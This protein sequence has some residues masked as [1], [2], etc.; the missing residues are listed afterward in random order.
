MQCCIS[1][2]T[3]KNILPL[4]NCS[5]N[6]VLKKIIEINE[7]NEPFSEDARIVF[8]DICAMYPNVEVNEAIEIIGELIEQFPCR[9]GLTKNS[10]VKALK[11]CQA[12]N[13]VKFKNK[14]Y[15]P[16]R[17]CAMGPAH[18]C[19]L[20]DIWV[21]GIATKHVQTCHSFENFTTIPLPNSSSFQCAKSKA[22]LESP[23]KFYN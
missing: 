15:L 22:Y 16:C 20:T 6:E 13:C 5:T 3:S 10:V 18:G 11:I 4:R 12:L 14:F 19:D 1:H 17:G 8:P 23:R 9:H 7:N 2:L 21:G